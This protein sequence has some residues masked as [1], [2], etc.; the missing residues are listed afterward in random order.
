[1]P[2]ATKHCGRSRLGTAYIHICMKDS[3]AKLWPDP[4]PSGN[5]K[6]CCRSGP[7]DLRLLHKYIN[8][9][10]ASLMLL[11]GHHALSSPTDAVPVLAKPGRVADL[12]KPR[13]PLTL[14]AVYS[15]IKK[16]NKMEPC[17]KGDHWQS[18]VGA[19]GSVRAAWGVCS[20][21]CWFLCCL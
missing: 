17:R 15:D 2:S 13:L 16:A 10:Q 6:I 21:P 3:C 11:R 19:A 9:I 8:L 18:L 4:F 7:G 1:M 14:C 12:A 20:S 5:L